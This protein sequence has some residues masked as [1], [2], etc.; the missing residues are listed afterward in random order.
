[1]YGAFLTHINHPSFVAFHLLF[2]RASTA[3]C[4]RQAKQKPQ[5]LWTTQT[6]QQELAQQKACHQKDQ[7][8]QQ[9]QKSRSL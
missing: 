8:Q 7:S 3:Q 6:M 1:M 5:V 4:R 9:Q 2:I